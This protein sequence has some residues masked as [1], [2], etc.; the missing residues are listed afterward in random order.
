MSRAAV[1]MSRAVAVEFRFLHRDRLTSRERASFSAW[2]EVVIE[3]LAIEALHEPTTVSVT[4]ET[5]VATE[6][7]LVAVATDRTNAPVAAVT[8]AA[9]PENIRV[10][11][12]TRRGQIVPIG[13]SAQSFEYLRRF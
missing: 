8:P 12:E 5:T 4:A 9:F 11:H 3:A 2:A 13:R 10:S 1:D 6:T 7:H